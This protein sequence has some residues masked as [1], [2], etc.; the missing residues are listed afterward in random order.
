M[1]QRIALVTGAN[2]GLGFE[3][4]RGL[5]EHGMTVVLGC[6]DRAKGEAARAQLVAETGNDNAV[7]MLVDLANLARLRN[8]V[9]AF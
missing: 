2:T 8:F 4:A 6:R 5:L 1:T 3:T 9:K 7:V